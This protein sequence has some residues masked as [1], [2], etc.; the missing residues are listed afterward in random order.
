MGWFYCFRAFDQLMSFILLSV[1]LKNSAK[2]SIYKSFFFFLQFYLT[3][4]SNIHK[5]LSILNFI[6]LKCQ[7]FLIFKI[8]S[9]SLCIITIINSFHSQELKRKDKN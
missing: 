1:G 5:K 8:I 4:F 7:F 6:S 3:T 9:F 2:I